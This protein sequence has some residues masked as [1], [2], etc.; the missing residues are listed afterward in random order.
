MDYSQ[1]KQLEFRRKFWKILGASI[2]MYNP[3]N[4]QV[5]GFIKMKAWK[6]RE[7]VRLYTDQSMQ[8]EVFRIGARNIIDI[9]ATYD[10]FD[11]TTNQPLFALR[12]KGLKSIFVR[13]HWDIFDPAGNPFG[14][15]QETSGTLALVRRWIG[16]LPFGDIAELI[17]AFAPQT[18]T[19]NQGDKSAPILLAKLVHRKNPL[20]VK[21]GLDTSAAQAA[22]DPRLPIAV[23]SLLMII[24]ASKN[25]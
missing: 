22:T 6:L 5:L 1:F 9:G 16:L 17:F 4:Q 3:T 14:Y 13:D 19:V 18:Y 21:M 12:R 10:V 11:S 23:A 7:D 25:S 2:T 24:D 20:I 8:Q 15:V